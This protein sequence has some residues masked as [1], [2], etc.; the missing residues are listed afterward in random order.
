M[1]VELVRLPGVQLAPAP[2]DMPEHRPIALVAV[3]PKGDRGDAG[4]GSCR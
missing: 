3:G 4:N 1:T 2:V